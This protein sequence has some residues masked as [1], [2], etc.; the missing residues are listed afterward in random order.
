MEQLNLDVFQGEYETV[1]RLY[2][3]LDNANKFTYK[4]SEVA[5]IVGL[6]TNQVSSIV[7]K[8]CVAYSNIVGC[9]ECGAAYELSGRNDYESHY[10]R[11]NTWKC[12]YCLEEE[13]NNI[14]IARRH[15]IIEFIERTQTGPIE[16]SELTLKESVYLLAFIRH[17]ANE[18]LTGFNAVTMNRTERLAPQTDSDSEL[19]RFL[20]KSNLISL[21]LDSPQHAFT[22]EGDKLTA[23]SLVN[24][25]W[26]IEFHEGD[27]LRNILTRI[28]ELLFDPEFVAGDIE[29]LTDLILEISLME[30]LAYLEYNLIEHNLPFKPGE[31]TRKVFLQALKTYSV[32]QIYNF[33]WSACKDAASYYMKGGISKRQ[34]ANAVVGSIQRKH[35]RAIGNTWNIGEFR[36]NYDLPQSIVSQVVFNFMLRTDDGGFNQ[37]LS[38][39]CR[40]LQ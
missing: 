34:A 30:C 7:K 9:I 1:C 17:S 4:V 19:V 15:E 16:V 10:Y 18:M 11:C 13:Q 6:N 24:S 25:I 39:F 35:E 29:E 36:R 14:L 23:F 37:K 40:E 33:I 2:W 8:S 22:F 31:K 38:F 32:A 21:S 3:E 5:K 26:Q 12:K 28:E 27:S 20:Y